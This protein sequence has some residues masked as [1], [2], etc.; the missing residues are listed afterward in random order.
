MTYHRV[1]DESLKRFKETFEEKGIKY[2]TE[3]EYREAAT[4][5]VVK[6]FDLLI[7]MDMEEKGRKKRLENEPKGYKLAGEGRNCS[8]CRRAVYEDDGWYDK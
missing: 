7:E 5:L 1:S 2:E 4:N 6:F 3:E 8:L